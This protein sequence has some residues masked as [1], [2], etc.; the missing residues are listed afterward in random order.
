MTKDN[1]I[2]V[3]KPTSDKLD[4]PFLSGKGEFNTHNWK[5]VGRV[6]LW[7]AVSA[8]I[9]VLIDLIPS[10]DIP[11]EYGFLVTVVNTLLYA[12]RDW[13]TVQKKAIT[14]PTKE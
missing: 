1:E 9:V 11:A 5:R 10:L 13:T 12:V 6:F 14:Q 3:I 4:Q 7:S 8:V 2:N